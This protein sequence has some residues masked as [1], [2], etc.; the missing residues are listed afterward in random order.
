MY[1][2]C[3]VMLRCVHVYESKYLL[4][5]MHDDGQS[6]FLADRFV[7]GE[8]APIGIYII[9]TVLLHTCQVSEQ[10]L[11][12]RRPI[13]HQHVSVSSSAPMCLKAPASLKI[14][15]QS[16]VVCSRFGLSPSA[17]KLRQNIAVPYACSKAYG[18][19]LIKCYTHLYGAFLSLGSLRDEKKYRGL[20]NSL[21]LS[22]PFG[23]LLPAACQEQEPA[24]LA[25]WHTLAPCQNSR[26][27]RITYIYICQ[28][29]SRSTFPICRFCH[30]TGFIAVIP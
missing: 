6:V 15:G 21:G 14:A 20:F 25:L 8:R 16:V 19:P 29:N 10:G 11:L 28:Q 12:S 13:H 18:S 30:R 23:Q 3:N 24:A 1:V 27:P 5:I 26:G 7:S 17:A 2:V 4:H 9:C 22:K